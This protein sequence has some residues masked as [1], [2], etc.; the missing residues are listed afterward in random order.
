MRFWMVAGLVMVSLCATARSEEKVDL[1]MLSRIK[2]EGIGNSKVMETLSDL[3]DR[4]GGRLSGSA[5]HQK[6][7]EWCRDALKGWGLDGAELESIG[8][9]GRSWSLNHYQIE[10]T[11]PYYL[12][13]IACPKAYT[14]GTDGVISGKPLLVV[15]NTAD[16]I[17]KYEGKLKGAIVLYGEP[18]APEPGFEADAK[19]YTADGLEELSR[20]TLGAAAR[21]PPSSQPRRDPA[22]FRA[23]RN[24]RERLNEAFRKE[25]VGCVLEASR[26]SDGTVFVQGG[27]SRD[28]NDAPAPPALVVSAEHYGLIA[29]LLKK[30]VDVDLKVAVETAFTDGK[31]EDFNVV[32][33]LPGADPQL[34]DELVMLG[35]HLD[36][37]H[38]ATGTTDNAAGCAVALEAI[39]I[40]KAIDC[41][42]RRTIR[43]ALWTGEEQGL[44]G[45]AAYVKAH[46]ADRSTMDLKPEHA[47]FAGYFNLDNGVG[48]IRGIY[49]QSNDAVKPIFE[50]WLK[51]FADMDAKT[52]TVRNT[53]GTDHQSFDAVGL[54]G[55]QFIQDEMDY[56][57]R[58]HH[59]NMDLY[60]RAVPDD[61]KQA[62][63][64]MAS[65]VYNTAMRD[66]KLPRKELP[67]PR[68]E[69]GNREGGPAERDGDSPASRP[70]GQAASERP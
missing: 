46:F 67:K 1:Q 61:L 39:R 51:P 23:R 47:K 32:A 24:V 62:S 20:A 16:D 5:N 65:F 66:E 31:A 38:S 36:S 11:A 54:P 29:R 17:K 26:S 43:V 30:G 4:H 68:R 56:D 14:A 12:N 63:V 49:C 2:A 27:G 48:K 33:E 42:P 40:L 34:K 69:R 28:P 3:V 21:R 15:A 45:S 13:L 19:R 18:N 10:M 50:E 7:A 41:K 35:G 55:F 22:E 59:S 6:A 57:S 60:E 9:V 25:G 8:D 58:T 64:I 37:W 44:L 70:G 52:V 53:G